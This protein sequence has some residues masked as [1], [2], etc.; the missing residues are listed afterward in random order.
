[1][2]SGEKNGSEVEFGVNGLPGEITGE[3]FSPPVR[4]IS[5]D[6]ECRSCRAGSKFS[7]VISSDLIPAVTIF[8]DGAK[9]F[10]AA[11]VFKAKVVVMA[12]FFL[13]Y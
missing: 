3:A 7:S 11:A 10:V 5:R 6:R 9:N 1:M 8:F 4:M 12:V 13:I 2:K